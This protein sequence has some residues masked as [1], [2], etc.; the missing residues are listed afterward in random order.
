LAH[1]NQAKS[2]W[3]QD[4]SEI[5]GGVLNNAR[6]ESNRHFRNVKREYLKDRIK[7]LAANS[8][9]KNFRDLYRRLNE[10]KSSNLPKHNLVNCLQIPTFQIAGKTIY[11]TY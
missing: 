7:E 8:K 5:N 11:L 10:Y 2:Q 3:L 6:Q 9:N 1:R 4:P